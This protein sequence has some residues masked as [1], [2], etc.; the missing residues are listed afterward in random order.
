MEWAYLKM[1]C[2]GLSNP[3]AKY[4]MVDE[5]QDYTTAQLVILQRYFRRA[6]F[7]LLG[8]ENQAIG[9]HTSTF[10]EIRAVFEAGG[11]SV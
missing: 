7:L 6:H 10:E 4:V 1:A 3:N 2:T 11:E 5:V 9:N 8:D